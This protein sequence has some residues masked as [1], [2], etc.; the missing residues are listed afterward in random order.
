MD[1]VTCQGAPKHLEANSNSSSNRKK[2]L[3]K[4]R[5]NWSESEQE[6]KKSKHFHSVKATKAYYRAHHLKM[7]GPSSSTA[8]PASSIGDK[9][10]GGGG[11]APPQSALTWGIMLLVLGSS[12]GFTLYSKKAGAMLQ[13]IKR[14]E[15]AQLKK[16]PPRVGPS[17]KQ[18]YEKLRPRIDKDDFF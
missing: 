11:G 5:S 1:D 13:G 14:V 3:S 8:L 16:H 12:A 9:S 6:P 10:G 2:L 18:E 17:T 7:S 15:A 4:D